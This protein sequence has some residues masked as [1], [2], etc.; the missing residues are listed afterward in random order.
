MNLQE[1]ELA[2]KR[3]TKEFIFKALEYIN[4]DIVINAE[5]IEEFAKGLGFNTSVNSEMAYHSKVKKSFEFGLHYC[6]RIVMWERED[7]AS[8]L[9]LIY[10]DYK[11][12]MTYKIDIIS[13]NDKTKVVKFQSLNER[14]F[15]F[16]CEL[17]GIHPVTKKEYAN[18]NVEKQ[19]SSEEYKTF[20]DFFYWSNEA[21]DK[22]INK[23]TD[24][25][26]E[27]YR[28]GGR[29]GC[30]IYNLQEEGKRSY[31]NYNLIKK[32]LR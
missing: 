21:T 31:L 2:S 24:E 27:A 4:T 5:R 30:I 13:T 25:H 18:G 26:K 16:T 9:Y 19:F 20:M 17:L 23:I 10:R 28:N 1:L 8:S 6:T 22:V 11:Y 3:N 29:A 7:F 32:A 15:N 12:Y 14:E